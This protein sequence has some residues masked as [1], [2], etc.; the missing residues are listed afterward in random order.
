MSQFEINISHS[1]EHKNI[2]IF[3]RVTFTKSLYTLS[4]FSR[5]VGVQNKSRCYCGFEILSVV[6][7][8]IPMAP[9][10]VGSCDG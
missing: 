1:T 10:L 5:G 8:I 6:P 2:K 4:F 7:G 9:I 3:T